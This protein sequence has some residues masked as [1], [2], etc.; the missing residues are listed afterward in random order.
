MKPSA[1]HSAHGTLEADAGEQSIPQQSTRE[2]LVLDECGVAATYYIKNFVDYTN[3][4]NLIVSTTSRFNIVN[5]DLSGYQAI[6]NIQR[7]NNIR[8]INK[9]FE[10]A[11]EMLHYDGL[12]IGAVETYKLRKKRILKKYPAGFNWMFY[13]LDFIIKRIFPK[14]KP[15]QKLY[16]LLTRGHNRVLSMA[17]SYGRLYSCGFELHDS[18]IIDGML[19]FVARKKGKPAFDY[20][21]TYGP[22]V[23]LNRIGK[24]GKI[25]K[26][27][28][29][30]TMHA[31]SEYLQEYIY[32]NNNLKEGGKFH[33]DF[34][35][36]TLGKIMRTCWLDELPMLINWFRGDM[37]LFGVRPL[38]K[39]YFNLYDKDLQ[40]K[41]I[42]HRPGLV[43]PYYADLPHTLEEIQNSERRYLEAYEKAPFRTDWVYFWK[44]FRNILLKKARSE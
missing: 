6:V 36:T 18:K 43:P 22:L 32:D 29:M 14:M 4:Q 15:T 40:E 35:I 8:R 20:N 13:T 30:R 5:N 1:N 42:Q 9:F 37:K 23:K 19:Y 25:I 27:Y 34:R 31:Y 10:A 38:S 39:H 24:G 33:N 7:I 3:P 28:K 12:F 2:K 11:N 17:E 26:V 21:P 44:A 16:F 41:R